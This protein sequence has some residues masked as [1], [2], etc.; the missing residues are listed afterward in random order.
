[1][2][3]WMGK[4][5]R[6]NLTNREIRE[7]PLK[8]EIAHKYV[9]GRGFTIRYLYD[10]LEAGIDPMGV[11]NKVMFAPGPACG[12]I[13]P[14]SQRWTVGAKSPI[15][16]FIGD[17]NCG[18]SF[19]VG[20]K[21]AGYDMVIVEGKSEAPVYLLMDDDDVQL[22]DATSLW[23]KTTTETER[24]IRKEVG[25]P[26][27]HIASIGIAGENLVKYATVQNDNRAAARTGMGTVMGSKKLKAVA[28]KGSKGVKVASPE[29]VEKVTDEMYRNWREN[30]AGLKNLHEYGAGVGAA[31]IYNQ[32]GVL[33]TKNYREGVFN[34]YDHIADRLKEDLWLKPRSCFSCPVACSHVYIVSQGPYAGTF[35]EG[36]YGP[37]IWYTATIG[38]NDAEFM[39]KLATL[40]DQY[41][42]DEAELGGIIAWLM[43]CYQLG[44]LTAEDLGGI[45]MEW[46]NTEALPEVIEMI[47]HRKGIGDLLAEGA[48]KASEV[49]GRG[50]E[51]YVMHVKGMTLD[52]RDPRGSKGWALGF[53]VG[54][55]GADHCR[56][57]VP[58]FTTGRSPEM[59][60]MKT[61]FDWFTGL[62]RFVE[63]GKGKTHKWFED[64]RAFQ[65]AL[66]NCIF[67]FESK[68]IVWSEV[69]AGM[70]TAVTGVDMSSSEVLITG[71]RIINLERAFNI[72]EGLTRKDDNLPERFLKESLPDGASKGQVVDLDLMLDEYYEAR[73]WDK[74][75]G[76]PIRQTLEGLGLKAV[77]DELDGLPR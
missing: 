44:I 2:Y 75:R 50:S 14:G 12:T 29:G 26:N 67:A 24:A 42:I 32:F 65:H 1:M 43:E 49:I 64:V 76:F 61:E 59:P 9:G 55:R 16:G 34:T 28:A 45:K 40:S 47:V 4:I 25:D 52:E 23:G 17:A 63:L 20:L 19:G 8:E 53:A 77:A 38:A 37:P 22:R 56:H 5:L 69:L 57:M 48:K 7:E 35:G 66:E 74:N 71:E 39:C 62:D 58:D 13:V 51:K 30:A 3:G 21:Y 6:V 68:D 36:L 41:G 31:R 11:K 33:Q 15:T 54:S 18:G 60:W 72:R 27:I 73:G 10:E 46:G 70:Y